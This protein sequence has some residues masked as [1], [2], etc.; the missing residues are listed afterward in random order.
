MADKRF[1]GHPPAGIDPDDLTGAL[2]VVEG[3][4]ASGRSTHIQLLTQWLE[5]RGYPVARTGLT[6]SELVSTEL[7]GAKLGNVLSPRTMALFYATDFYDQM[8]NV[9]VPS[10]RAGSVVIADRYIFTL[11]ARDR[12]RGANKDWLDSLYSMAIVPDAVF[13]FSISPELLAE[14]RLTSH[15]NLDYWESGM[16]LGLSRDWYTSFQKYQ[17]MMHEE[18]DKLSAEYD[19]QVIQADDSLEDVQNR[20]REAVMKAVV[21]SYRSPPGKTG[22]IPKGPKHWPNIEVS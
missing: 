12:V 8:E 1:Y 16:D 15:K 4:D 6:R 7:D 20:L 3:P 9:I 14:R 18:F 17:E 13:Y 11:M 5:E 2:I 19:F 10:M 22:K 21:K